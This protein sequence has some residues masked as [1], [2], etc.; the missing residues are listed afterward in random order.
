MCLVHPAAFSSVF[1]CVCGNGF[2]KREGTLST[3]HGRSFTRT[4]TAGDIE[5]VPRANQVNLIARIIEKSGKRD[6]KVAQM[7]R[8]LVCLYVMKYFFF[9]SE[10]RIKKTLAGIKYGNVK[11]WPES[12]W[13]GPRICCGK[14]CTGMKFIT[15]NPPLKTSPLGRSNWSTKEVFRKTLQ[16][17]QMTM[18]IIIFTAAASSIFFAVSTAAALDYSWYLSRS[19]FSH[20]GRGQFILKIRNYGWSVCWWWD[21]NQSLKCGRPKVNVGD[22]GPT[23][24]SHCFV[25]VPLHLL[26]FEA[27]LY[28]WKCSFLRGALKE[29]LQ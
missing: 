1:V 6:K 27:D 13:N 15:A 14:W 16:R 11:L 18:A 4:L 24:P 9:S 20:T 26:I 19:R 10:R 2:I 28:C 29:L 25:F 3:G 23:F 21:I 8:T 17:Q 5:V 22:V 7:V 12:G